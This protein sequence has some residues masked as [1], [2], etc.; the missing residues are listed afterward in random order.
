MLDQDREALLA[1]YDFPAEHWK[2]RRTTNVI[3]SSFATIRHRTVRSKEMSLQQD[4]AGHDLQACRGRRKKLAAPRR[5][6]PLGRARE[7]MSWQYA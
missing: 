1:F 7:D 6:P 4:G 5:P 2:H 3:E